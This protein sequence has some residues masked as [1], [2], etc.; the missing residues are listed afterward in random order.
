MITTGLAWDDV[1][2]VHFTLVSTTQLTDSSITH[3]HAFTLLSIPT[4]VELI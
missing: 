3:E 4:R 1:I 2:D